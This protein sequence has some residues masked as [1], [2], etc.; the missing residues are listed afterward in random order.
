MVQRYD[1]IVDDLRQMGEC[2][3]GYFVSYEDYAAQ[4]ELL[5]RL[6]DACDTGE[7]RGDGTISG[8]A[9]P[10]RALLEE[11]RGVLNK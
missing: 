7:R 4:E 3:D 9:V 2:E 8:A 6:F 10:S 5:N 11:V 1:L